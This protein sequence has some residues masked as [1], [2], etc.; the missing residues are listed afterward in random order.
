MNVSKLKLLLKY[1]F[2]GIDSVMEYL[3]DIANR[4]LKSIEPLTKERVAA[5]YNVVGSVISTMRALQW[6][7]PAKWQRAYSATLAMLASTLDALSDFELTQEELARLAAAF[8]NGVA[9]WRSDDDPK[10]DVDFSM[11]ED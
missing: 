9:A 6:L 10:T 3:L 1:I 2:G 8:R 5:A 4:A 7:C 11:L